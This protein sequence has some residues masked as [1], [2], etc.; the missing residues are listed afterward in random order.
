M[1]YKKKIAGLYQIFI[2][3]QIRYLHTW[4]TDLHA[5]SVADLEI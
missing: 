1:Q 2:Q 4:L 5:V 3:E